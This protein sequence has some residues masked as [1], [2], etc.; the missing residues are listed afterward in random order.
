M[1]C[2]RRVLRWPTVWMSAA[3]SPGTGAATLGGDVSVGGAIGTVGSAD[4]G[5]DLGVTGD[6]TLGG[7]TN[8]TLATPIT[9]SQDSIITATGTIQPIRSAAATS[10]ASIFP[11]TAGDVLILENMVATAITFTDTGTLKLSANAVLNQYDTLT[12]FSDGVNWIE[13]STSNN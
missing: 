3:I 9:V 7:I 10:T 2:Y 5:G 6:S 4:I 1:S 12:L 11:G 8:L 13:L